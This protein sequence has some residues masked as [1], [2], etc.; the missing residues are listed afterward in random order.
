MNADAFRHVYNYHFAWNRLIWERYVSQLSDEQL[1]QPVDYS[2]GSVRDQLVHLM[3][4]DE[5]WFCDLRGA[6][7]RAPLDPA[8]GDDRAAIRARWDAVEGDMRGYLEA[9]RDD[10]L[11]DK[12]L[13][14]EDAGLAL[15]QILLHVI[16]HG[17]DHRAQV[18]RVL[19]DL[20][21]ETT[22]QDYVF[23]AYEAG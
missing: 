21:V 9:L 15:W 11:F 19:H 8:Q 7:F 23:Y 4:V 3:E 16:N 10:M 5:A 14:G 22:S 12:P 2:L 18:L 17:T 13:E 6:D 1:T 20:G